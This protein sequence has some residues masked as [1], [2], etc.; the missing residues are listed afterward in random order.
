LGGRDNTQIPEKHDEPEAVYLLD[1]RFGGNVP[2]QATDLNREIAVGNSAVIVGGV[3]GKNVSVYSGGLSKGGQITPTIVGKYIF[4][5]ESVTI[6]RCAGIGGV[7]LSE[8]EVTVGKEA[9][10]DPSYREGV[11]SDGPVRVFGPVIARRKIAVLSGVTVFGDLF[12]ENGEASLG[13]ESRVLGCIFADTVNMG[14]LSYASCIIG[15]Q[16]VRIGNRVTTMSPVVR[17]IEGQVQ[18]TFESDSMR[19]LIPEC[20]VCERVS[21]FLERVSCPLYVSGQCNSYRRISADNEVSLKKGKAFDGSL[22]LYLKD[23]SATE[24][25]LALLVR[26]FERELPETPSQLVE[27]ELSIGAPRTQAQ[28]NSW[29]NAELVRTREY[30][31]LI[32]GAKNHSSPR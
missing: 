9:E 6:H 15:K 17:C 10:S 3:F 32:D 11:T 22:G 27:P 14:D 28:L 2:R 24:T 25:A 4:G 21:N 31:R 12:C 1:D 16:D 7:V 19:C 18:F 29:V 26:E 13:Y 30:I 20:A 5:R 23:R 8:G